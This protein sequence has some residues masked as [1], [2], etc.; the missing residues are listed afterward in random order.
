MLNKILGFFGLSKTKKNQVNSTNSNI[1]N[2]KNKVKKNN[3]I[4]KK[5]S[6]KSKLNI[7]EIDNKKIKK[8]VKKIK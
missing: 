8:Q 2:S 1:I 3:K 5:I 6:R 7:Y 4:K